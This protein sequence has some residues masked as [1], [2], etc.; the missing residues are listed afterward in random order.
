MRLAPAS[1]LGGP[2]TVVARAGFEPLGYERKNPLGCPEGSVGFLSHPNLF[3]VRSLPR[4][5][6]D[7][8]YRKTGQLAPRRASR[9]RSRC[10]DFPDE[11][12]G[13]TGRPPTIGSI[14]PRLT[15]L[16]PPGI[17][18]CQPA[19]RLV[20]GATPRPSERRVMLS[21]VV[22]RP[23]PEGT[24]RSMSEAPQ[25]RRRSGYR[26]EIRPLAQARHPG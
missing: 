3:D 16:K 8:S 23:C 9:H 26:Q 15:P 6:A 21:F 22:V 5:T 12:L 25:R 18:A 13:E 11:C 14:Q 17:P 7:K 4:W 20:T 1:A 19:W 10:P 2:C 24:K